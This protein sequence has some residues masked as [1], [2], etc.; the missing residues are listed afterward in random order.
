MDL[1]GPSL[2]T[3]KELAMAAVTQ[4][5]WALDDA[6]EVMKHDKE[7]VMAAVMQS[8]YSLMYAAES[9]EHDKEVLM[10][11]A[12]HGTAAAAVKLV[13]ALMPYA[14]CEDRER[15]LELA[16]E[17]LTV[18][19]VTDTSPKVHQQLHSLVENMIKRTYHPTAK[20]GKRGRDAFEQDFCE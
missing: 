13:R 3:D 19:P 4:H 16:A 12:R 20:G 1:S 17:L 14:D 8:G 7:V 15:E 2:R 9:M 10:R 5:G 6:A 11:H 18:F